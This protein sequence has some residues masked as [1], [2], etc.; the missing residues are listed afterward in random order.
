[1]SAFRQFA[2]R[3]GAIIAATV[4]GWFLLAGLSARQGLI[5]D[6]LGVVLGLAT[7]LCAWVIHEW[8]HL[9]AGMAAGAQMRAPARWNSVFLFGFDVKTSSQAQFVIM[10][11]GGFAATAAMFAFVLLAL[12]ADLLAARVARGLV[13]LEIVVTVILEVPG[14]LLGI[15]A[16][17]RMP[18]VDVLGD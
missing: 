7:G 13:M 17:S 8:G 9:L 2:L 15:F 12:P 16:Y 18:S 4:L 6:F 14:L 3:D 10:A 11:L 5:G 1:M